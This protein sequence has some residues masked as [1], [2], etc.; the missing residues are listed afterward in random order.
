LV[1]GGLPIETLTVAVRRFFCNWIE[2]IHLTRLNN[3]PLVVN[4]DLIK[5]IENAPDTVIT[6][7]TG[8]KLVVRESAAE[9]L[10]RIHEFHSQSA[11]RI[12]FGLSKDASTGKPD[13]N[14]ASLPPVKPPES[15]RS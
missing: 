3:T 6:L 5:F 1:A 7:I 8:E 12:V 4:A 2:M 14:P 15:G 10:E 11:H 13:S 9:I